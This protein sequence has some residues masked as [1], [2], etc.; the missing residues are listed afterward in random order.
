MQIF[1]SEYTQQPVPEGFTEQRYSYLK[2]MFDIEIQLKPHWRV[3]RRI[4][5]D[6]RYEK[7]IKPIHGD[8]IFSRG[9]Q[10]GHHIDPYIY[11]ALEF[12]QK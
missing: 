10:T 6:M 5:S 12:L 3:F 1:L 8:F 11:A 7:C 9:S 2:D 4:I